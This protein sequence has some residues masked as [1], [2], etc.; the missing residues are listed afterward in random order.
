MTVSYDSI[1]SVNNIDIKQGRSDQISLMQWQF[2]CEQETFQNK[3][4]G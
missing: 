1:D 3:I 2:Y 4:K